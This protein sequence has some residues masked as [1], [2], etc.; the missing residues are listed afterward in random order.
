[1]LGCRFFGLIVAEAGNPV[2]DGQRDHFGRNWTSRE[3]DLD[4][5]MSRWMRGVDPAW[6]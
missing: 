2:L 6:P 5:S 1:M 3:T 4:A